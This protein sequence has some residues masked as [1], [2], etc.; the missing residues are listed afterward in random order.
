MSLSWVLARSESGPAN[1][2]E[3]PLPEPS[4]PS[5]TLSL[6]LREDDQEGRLQAPTLHWLLRFRRKA[7][8][9]RSS[10]RENQIKSD[11]ERARPGAHGEILS[12]QSSPRSW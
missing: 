3:L 7:G 5:P 10:V 6:E 8:R 12:H 1:L 9:A 11:L 4:S 2:Q